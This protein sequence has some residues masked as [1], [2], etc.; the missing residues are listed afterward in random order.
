VDH[1]DVLDSASTTGCQNKYATSIIHRFHIMITNFISVAN[2]L[3]S[4]LFWLQI[5]SWINLFHCGFHF[6]CYSPH[7]SF[8]LLLPLQISFQ[9]QIHTYK[10][11]ISQGTNRLNDVD[12]DHFVYIIFLYII[13]LLGDTI[14]ML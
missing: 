3:I 14:G 10:T 7:T 2:S 4:F 13:I 11:S 9:L 12:R 6:S 1:M 8:Q 5:P